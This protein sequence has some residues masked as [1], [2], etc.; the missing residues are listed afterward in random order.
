MKKE[1]DLNQFEYIVGI[2]EV[3]L[4]SIAGPVVAVAIMFDKSTLQYLRTITYRPKKKIYRITDSKQLPPEIRE[5][6]NEKILTLY[7][8][9]GYGI[10][11]I[12]EL[13]QI[14]N[15][16]QGGMIA[17]SRALIDLLRW[18]EAKPDL[19]LVDGPKEFENNLK[20]IVNLNIIAVVKG[21]EKYVSISAASIVAKVFRDNV[22][23]KLA[24]ECPYYDWEHNAGY[25]SPKHLE[26]IRK[27]GISRHHRV[28]MLHN[29]YQNNDETIE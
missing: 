25:R 4:G 14:Q 1:E 7:K 20:Q 28:W 29:R 9:I 6:F 15:I 21:D 22:M 27:Y 19:V 2:D 5:Y 23:K 18:A 10:V 26:G 13:N 3:G 12:E 8:S 24:E 17:R 16:Y 11:T